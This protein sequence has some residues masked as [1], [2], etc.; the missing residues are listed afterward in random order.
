MSSETPLLKQYDFPKL[1]AH[2]HLNSPDITLAEI[3]DEL[4]F[5]LATINTEAPFFPSIREQQEI[6]HKAGSHNFICTFSTEQFETTGWQDEAICQIETGMN[7]GAVGVKIWKNVGMELKDSRGN[8][9]MADHPDYDPIY[10]YLSAN[11]IPLLAHLGEPKNCWLPLDEM[12]VT[13]DRDYFSQH[14]EYHMFLNKE[15]PNYQDQLDARD[16]ILEKH[17]GLRFVGAH[18]ASIEWSVD[19]LATW[20]NRFPNA[21]VDLAERVC[22][23]QHQ[24]AENP[25]KV[26]EFIETYHDRIIYGS[27]QIDDGTLSKLELQR[28]IFHKWES[29]FRFFAEDSV[30]TA[31]NVSKPFQGLGL[32][33][34]ILQIIFYD[35]A[36]KFYTRLTN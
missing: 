2:V 18:L 14:P 8:Y 25:K 34:S 6:A 10:Q 21:G 11:S 31:Q 20:L 13:S 32:D 17:P 35:N 26:K 9:V 30:Q 23:L 4:G 15:M 1:D 22:H 16:R 19:E 33:A 28:I 7:E 3:A 29:E 27:D 12:T 5:G 36:I 24:A